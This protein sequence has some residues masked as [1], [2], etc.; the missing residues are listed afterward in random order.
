MSRQSLWEEVMESSLESNE[1]FQRGL[2]NALKKLHV[3]AKELSRLSGISESSLYKILSGERANPRLS[4]YRT[5]IK[6]IKRL[7]G[8]EEGEPFI[9]I[10][11]ARQTLDTIETR[12]I[13]IKNRRIPIREYAATTIED[14]IVAAVRAQQEGAGAIVCAPI[15]STVVEKV[16]KVPVSACPVALCKQPILRAAETAASKIFGAQY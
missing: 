7:E 14:V 10:I 5:I 9:A 6:T 4:T 8:V 16:T 1:A 12:Y 11:A 2:R 15:V 3:D 13:E